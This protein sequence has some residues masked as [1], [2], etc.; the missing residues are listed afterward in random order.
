MMPKITRLPQG[1]AQ[2]PGDKQQG[3]VVVLALGDIFCWDGNFWRMLGGRFIPKQMREDFLSYIQTGWPDED[4]AKF[5]LPSLFDLSYFTAY[6]GNDTVPADPKMVEVF[7]SRIL[8]A[9]RCIQSN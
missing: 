3:D 6:D 4:S 5:D 9:I 2:F 7:H 8:E 1:N